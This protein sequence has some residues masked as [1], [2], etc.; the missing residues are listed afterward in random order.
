MSLG[1]ALLTIAVLVLIGVF[2]AWLHILGW[3]LRSKRRADAGIDHSARAGV[4]M[5][6]L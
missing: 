6:R 4:L 3:G 1:T 2:S 5:G